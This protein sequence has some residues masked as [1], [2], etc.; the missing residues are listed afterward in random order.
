MGIGLNSGRVMSGTFGSDRRIDYAVIGDTTNTAARIQ[1]LTKQTGQLDPAR[2][3]DADEHDRLHGRPRRSSTSS[4][5]AASS[6][7]SSCGP[8]TRPKARHRR[9]RHAIA[10][11]GPGALYRIAETAS[12]AQDMQEFYAEIHRIVGELMYAEQLLHRPVR[13]GATDDQLAVRRRRGG[14]TPSPTRTS[15]SRWGPARSR[16]LTAYVLRT[17]RPDAARRWPDIDDLVQ[18]GEV[19]LRRRALGSTGSASRCDRRAEPSARSS[20]RATRESLPTPSRT[21]TS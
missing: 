16:G 4:T 9:E 11:A 8:R 6:R 2:R 10:R 7:G 19:E 20:S 12:A 17:G 18:R 1:D 3:S 14:S 15:G 5:S 13:R 21:R